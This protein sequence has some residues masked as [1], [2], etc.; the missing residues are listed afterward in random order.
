MRNLIIIGAGGHARPVIDIAQS[1][2]DFQESR[3][4]LMCIDTNYSGQDEDILGVP[5]IGG[6]DK[7]SDFS[8]EITDIFVAIG[9]N[10]ERKKISSEIQAL[11][12]ELIELVHKSAI[13]TT[14]VKIGAGSLVCAGAILNP[15]VTIGEGCIINTGAI[16]DHETTIEDFAHIAPGVKIAG[17][18]SIGELTFVGIGSVIID[19]IKIG[20]RAIIGAS[21]VILGDVAEGEKVVGIYKRKI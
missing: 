5:V 12:F 15:D 9:D 2:T 17:R 6:M 10:A 18:V 13:L 20:A 1:L 16:V 7:L 8:T 21:S 3:L 14:N 4:E 19:K 11:G